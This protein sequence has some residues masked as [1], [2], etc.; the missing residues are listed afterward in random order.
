MRI[1]KVR[2]IPIMVRY[3][4]HV[5][6]TLNSKEINHGKNE[7]SYYSFDIKEIE[8]GFTWDNSDD[9]NCLKLVSRYSSY[10]DK[11]N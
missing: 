6:T 1:L 3:I 11:R 2:G 10:H 5:Y 7:K 8:A 9:E 4:Q